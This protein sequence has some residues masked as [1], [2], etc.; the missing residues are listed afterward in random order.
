[1]PGAPLVCHV[2]LV[3]ARHGLALID[4][5][6]GRADIADPKRRIGFYRHVIRPLLDPEE[7]AVEQ[8]RRL[9]FAPADVRDIVLTHFDADHIGGLADFPEARVHTTGDEWE[10]ASSR[11]TWLESSRYRPAQWEHAP[12]VVTHGAGGEAWRGF[13]AAKR[14]AEIDDGVVLIPLP[15]HTRGHAA[16]AVDTGGRWIFHAG[17]AFYDRSVL[18][19]TGRQPLV[20]TVQE[21][22]VAH[23]WPRL[24]ANQERLAELHRTDPDVLVISA[25]DPALFEHARARGAG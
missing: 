4:T 12:K 2:L 18:Q 5:G 3:E 9:G 6:F 14:L 7:T 20:L 1:M 16:V 21:W 13:T 17:D 10:A 23:D 22:F 15:G 24:R 8:V 11:R 19:R 25:H